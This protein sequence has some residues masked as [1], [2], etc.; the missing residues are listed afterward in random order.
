MYSLFLPPSEALWFWIFSSDL[1]LS[2]LKETKELYV[3]F[4][5]LACSFIWCLCWYS[6]YNTKYL[7]VFSE[8]GRW[9]IIGLYLGDC[10]KTY[11]LLFDSQIRKK[12]EDILVSIWARI[13][14]FPSGLSTS[15]QWMTKGVDFFCSLDDVLYFMTLM[16][17]QKIQFIIIHSL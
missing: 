14:V 17:Y 16:I 5:Y 15:F 12:Q 1:F 10:F 7:Q 2:Q 4:L 3:Q 9:E 13:F 8:S 6:N 11:T